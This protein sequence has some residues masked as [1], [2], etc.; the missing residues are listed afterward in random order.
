MAAADLDGDGQVEVV[1]T[2]S[3]I[4]PARLAVLKPRTRGL[5]WRAK[6]LI[7]RDEDRRAL[8]SLQL[9]DLDGDGALEIF[10]VEMENGK[11]DGLTSKPEWLVLKSAGD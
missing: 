11:T 2:E 10:T 8:H 3:E 6:I 5:P 4:G 9:V 7:D 1:I